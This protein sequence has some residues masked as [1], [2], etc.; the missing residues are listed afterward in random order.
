MA[1]PQ[2]VSY[3]SVPVEISVSNVTKNRDWHAEACAQIHSIDFPSL[4]DIE[5]TDSHTNITMLRSALASLNFPSETNS[6][7]DLTK[8]AVPDT[9]QGSHAVE[10]WRGAFIPKDQPVQGF[11]FDAQLSDFIMACSGKSKGEKTTLT[12]NMIGFYRAPPPSQTENGSNDD[13]SLASAPSS[14]R[15]SLSAADTLAVDWDGDTIL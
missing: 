4:N 14:R 10:P 6:V 5:H 7:C 11:H 13:G 15:S 9:L 1:D 12:G 2:K 8:Y 3:F